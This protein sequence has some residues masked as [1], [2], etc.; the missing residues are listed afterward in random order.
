MLRQLLDLD[1]LEKLGQ[2]F[3]VVVLKKKSA[4][5]TVGVEIFGQLWMIAHESFA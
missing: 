2:G 3:L 1:L 5:V 4:V